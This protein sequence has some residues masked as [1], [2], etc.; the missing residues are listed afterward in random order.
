MSDQ[1]GEAIRC[2]F[3]PYATLGV[4]RDARTAAIH[5]AYRAL[6]R[7][8]HPDVVPDPEAHGRMADINAAWRILRDPVLRA[9]WNA[10]CGVTSLASPLVHRPHVTMSRDDPASGACIWQRGPHGEGA[11]GPP[12]GRPS[13]SVLRFG[14]HLCW[15]I[16]EIARVDPGYL[17]WLAARPEGRPF[18]EEIEAIL[19]RRGVGL[20][21]R[22]PA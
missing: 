9:S 4:A 6:A 7:R 20:P 21:S 5:A 18:Q 8:N 3:D 11:A 1:A 22:P 2:D 16:G 10:A 15:S 13:G 17:A 14:R 19:H 12:P